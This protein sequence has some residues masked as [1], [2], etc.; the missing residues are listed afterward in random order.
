M[1]AAAKYALEGFSEALSREIKDF[2]IKLLILEPG[3]IRTEIGSG[4]VAARPM[5]EYEQVL[6]EQRARWASGE[7]SHAHGDADRCLRC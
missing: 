3:G 1:Y 4:I 5:P 2:G 6:G 7:D